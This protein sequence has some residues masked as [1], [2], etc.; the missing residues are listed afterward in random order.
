M[1]KTVKGGPF[2]STFVLLQNIKKIEGGPFGDIKVSKPKGGSL[3][4]PK[5][6]E[7]CF[8]MLAKS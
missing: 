5:N 2:G 3:V 7:T 1:P 4:E 8:E 6:V